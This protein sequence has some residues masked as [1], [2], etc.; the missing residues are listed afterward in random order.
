MNERFN[1]MRISVELV[2]RSAQALAEELDVLRGAF[3]EVATVNIPDLLRFPLRSWDACAQA[4]TCLP[5]A[6]AHIRAIDVDLS[7]PLPMAGTLTRHG[8]GEVLVVTGDMPADLS[9]RVYASTPLQVIRKFREELPG[10]RVYAALDP[11]RQ[12]FAQER[13]YAL[14]KLEAGA[15]GLFTQ[16]FFDLRLLEVYADLL[17]G[18]E[19]FWGVTTV[20]GQ[21][22]LGY[23]Q[24]RNRAV[25]PQD[26]E[27]TLRHS[28][29][30]AREALELARERQANLYFMPI[31]VG[32]REYLEGIL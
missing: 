5:H 23:W 26:F 32:V 28:R 8:I 21:R 30:L 29:K 14:R 11:Y 1:F 7:R 4:R 3:P 10:V 12:S 24:T 13:D 9:R 19:V 25:F 16:P 31:R 27:P 15:V 18:V 2:P 6:I 22:A 20:T 17:P